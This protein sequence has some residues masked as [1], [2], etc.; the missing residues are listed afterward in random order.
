MKKLFRDDYWFAGSRKGKKIIA[1]WEMFLLVSM[2][3]AVA[4]LMSQEVG[5]GSAAE[6]ELLIVKKGAPIIEETPGAIS[7]GAGTGEVIMPSVTLTPANVPPVIDKAAIPSAGAAPPAA[8]TGPFAFISKIYGGK[9]IS[10]TTSGAVVG[11]ALISGLA[12]AGTVAL[13]IKLVGNLFGLEKGLTNSLALSAFGG[14]LAYRTLALLAKPN[15]I[16]AQSIFGSSA[17]A[18]ATAAPFIGL[19]IAA[20]IFILTYKTEKKKTITFQCLPWEAPI[21]GADC[22]KCNTDKFRPCSE[23]RC[24]AL[25]QA[26]QI[27]NPGTAEESCVWVNSKDVNSPTIKPGLPLND[28]LKYV[29]DT[30]I[31]PPALGVKIIKEGATGGCLQAYT[32]LKF[33]FETN[34]PSQCM[35]DYQHTGN[36]N[37]MTYY[38]G[39]SNYYLYNHTQY[40]KLPGLD[41]GISG[42]G[43]AAPEIKNDGT[44]SMYIRCRDANGNENVDEFSFSFCVDKGP[45]TTPPLIDGSSIASGSPVQYNVDSVPIDIYVNEPAECKWSRLDKAYS[46]MENTMGC[47]TQTYQINSNLDYTCSG[48]LTGIKNSEENKFYFRCKDNPGKAEKDRNTNTQSFPLML[49]GTQS[50]NILKTSPNETIYGSTSTITVDLG[51]ESANGAEEGKAIC[52][53]SNTGSADSFVS[54]FETNSNVHKQ[55][56]DLTSGAY[57]YYFRCIDAGGNA[58]EGKT[59]FNVFVDKQAPMITRIYREGTDALKIV[60]NENAECTYS[61]TSCNFAIAEGIKMNYA[62]AN[63]K[64]IQITEW[65]PNVVYYMRC[66]DEFGNEPLSNSCSIVASASGIA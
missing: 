47:A 65:K 30:A 64:N 5:L 44:Y 53:F 36:M 15:I 55:T 14:I 50:L 56:L 24:K 26:C 38:V 16:G 1:L 43:T 22:E 32:P 19:G 6:E 8:G 51:V 35:I 66:K 49:R 20:A 62:G 28:G 17:G 7:G 41:T 2:G 52:Y 11:N 23:Y 10:G 60:T 45:D 42:N 39:E 31:R 27:V 33:S 18:L 63:V 13:G 12:W 29:P 61:L 59:S 9:I 3:F 4:F 40:M 46:D 58:A 34:E 48:A 54:M 37:N 21:G 25:G 57:T